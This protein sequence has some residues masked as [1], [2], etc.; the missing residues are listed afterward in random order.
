MNI[1]LFRRKIQ[2]AKKILEDATCADLAPYPV[3]P[4][5]SIVT[6]TKKKKEIKD[7]SKE[8]SRN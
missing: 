7:E 6:V 3:L 5:G 4:V 8:K 2:E 1:R